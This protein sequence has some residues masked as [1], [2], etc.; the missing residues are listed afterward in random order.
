MKFIKRR[1]SK[2]P[3]YFKNGKLVSQKIVPQVVKDADYDLEIVLPDEPI[4][5][6]EVKECLACGEEGT[7]RKY[8]SGVNFRLCDEHYTLKTGALAKLMQEKK[9]V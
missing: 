3:M 4:Q 5:V 9:L 2:A 6:E 1:G 7:K 8:L